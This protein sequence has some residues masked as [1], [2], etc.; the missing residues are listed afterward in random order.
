[1]KAVADIRAMALALVVA[2][3]LTLA[4]RAILAQ[5]AETS[6]TVTPTAPAQ[7][8]AA[9]A[10]RGVSPGGAFLRA[11]ALPGW[12]HTS[13][14]THTRAAF[15]IG[16]EGM[17][18]YSLLRTQSRIREVRARADLRTRAL[19]RDL[20]AAGVTDP[21]EIAVALEEDEALE[22]LES[23]AAS[24]GQQRED[25]AALGLFLL[26][27]SGA[28]AYVSAHLQNFPEPIELEMAPSP[29]GGVAVGL[30]IPLGN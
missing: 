11:V 4:P 25:W 19:R 15:Y 29:R 24:R 1:M 20:E 7:D 6:E 16:L 26:F 2:S 13:I 9:P 5:T 18:A 27:L 22:D 3:A 8:S 30:R 17:T 14:G 23:L 12:G 10:P 28:D 21:E